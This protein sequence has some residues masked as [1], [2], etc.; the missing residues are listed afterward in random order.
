MNWFKRLVVKWVR[1]DW[2]DQRHSNRQADSGLNIAI[3][4]LKAAASFEV[5]DF[6]NPLRFELTPA[7]G[8]RILTVRHYDPKHDRNETTTYV[9]PTGEDIGARVAK[10]LNLEL[11]K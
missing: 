4:R 2:E 11:L 6:D 3:P 8:G 7:V 1:E 10:I 5:S 9:I